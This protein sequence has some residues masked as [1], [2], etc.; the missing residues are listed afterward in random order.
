MYTTLACALLNDSLNVQTSLLTCDSRISPTTIIKN[1]G[2]KQR[3]LT[4]IVEEC[5]R[6]NGQIDISRF[7]CQNRVVGD[8][9]DGTTPDNSL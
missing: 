2:E 1:M 4:G 6:S 7:N 8:A 5:D 3:T 9:D